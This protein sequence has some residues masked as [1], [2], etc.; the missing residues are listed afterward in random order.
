MKLK[1]ITFLILLGLP[2][3]LTASENTKNISIGQE[4]MERIK[5]F[6]K[7]NREEQRRILKQSSQFQGLSKEQ[8]D[9]MLNILEN[10]NLQEVAEN[11]QKKKKLRSLYELGAGVL[12]AKFPDYPG[13]EHE[14]KVLLPFPSVTIRGEILRAKRDEG[15]R[16]RFIKKP[17]Y[18]LDLSA[19]GTLPSKSGDNKARDGMPNLDLVLELGPRLIVHLFNHGTLTNGQ[20]DLHLATR[21]GF[22]SDIKKWQDL[23]LQF[24]PYLSYKLE[25]FWQDET[26]FLITFGGKWTTR[27]LQK[28]YY[29]V[30]NSYQT[31]ARPAYHAKS[32]FLETS[33]SASIYYPLV[34]SLWIFL[35]G[36]KS[37]YSS[38]ANRKSPLLAKSNTTSVVVGLYWM[39]HKSKILVWD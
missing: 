28:Y 23:G 31:T 3:Y 14:H 12:W 27:K 18:E 25:N 7:L 29:Q 36:I 13:A 15:V 10:F 35:G 33:I 34:D 17:R 22:S 6:Q 38:A 8:Q 5:H 11:I 1:W 20:L 4:Q 2:F 9:K 24:N 21:Y 37:F 26:L 39:F 30:D 19:D 16:G 32:G